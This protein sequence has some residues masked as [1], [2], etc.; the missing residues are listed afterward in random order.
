MFYWIGDYIIAHLVD[1][2]LAY[3]TICNKTDWEFLPLSNVRMIR[4]C[5]NNIIA[6]TM[7]N[8][9]F[10]IYI[11]S[12]PV[13]ITNKI[14]KQVNISDIQDMLL[15]KRY[16]IVL[17]HD[18]I[19][20]FYH[21]DNKKSTYASV[22]EYDKIFIDHSCIIAVKD[23]YIYR[24]NSNKRE[25]EFMTRMFRI[26]FN[27]AHLTRYI[28]YHS[29]GNVLMILE[30]GNIFDL[31]INYGDKIIEILA[32]KQIVFTNIGNKYNY[33]PYFDD[34]NTDVLI[35]RD[36]ELFCLSKNMKLDKDDNIPKDY[37]NIL[38][39]CYYFDIFRGNDYYINYT[40]MY[41]TTDQCI[42]RYDYVNHSIIKEKF[43]DESPPYIQLEQCYVKSA[44]NKSS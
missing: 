13:D 16:I 42:F 11:G 27:D 10:M 29:S 28:K 1:G 4:P 23:E 37:G 25:H 9:L 26:K 6:L 8:R 41:V 19:A 38:S 30:N 2:R 34:I 21:I 40:D 17:T 39:I 35:T 7:S 24:L 33:N 36:N 12:D 32:D 43:F 3:R 15:F 22:K 18:I 44:R 31:S 5:H 20:H 14:P